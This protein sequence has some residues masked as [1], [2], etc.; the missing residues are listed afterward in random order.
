MLD[1]WGPI[2]VREFHSSWSDSPQTTAKN[3]STAK[4]FFEF[5]LSNEWIKRNPARLVKN[6]P[7]RDAADRRNEQNLPFTDEELL[8]VYVACGGPE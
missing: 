5:C 1:P 7:G 3:M 8:K 6:Q 4:A 2:D